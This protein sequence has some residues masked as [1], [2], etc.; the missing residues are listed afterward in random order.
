[1]ALR[2]DLTIKTEYLV[3]KSDS[4]IVI[5]LDYS[6]YNRIDASTPLS[7]IVFSIITTL[8]ICLT[9]MYLLTSFSNNINEL[10]ISPIEKMLELVRNKDYNYLN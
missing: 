10:I 1:M 4:Q 8:F 2:S 6:Q 5:F 7:I 9:I 3:D